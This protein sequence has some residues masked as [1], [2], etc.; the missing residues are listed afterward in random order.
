M[1]VLA[2]QTGEK[3]AGSSIKSVRQNHE[4]PPFIASHIVRNG[5]DGEGR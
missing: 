5:D 3:G 1:W 4:R 2:I